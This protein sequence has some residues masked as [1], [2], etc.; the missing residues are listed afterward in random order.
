M[1]S[2]ADERSTAGAGYLAPE[3]CRAIVDRT[4]HPF[5]ALAPDGTVTFASGSIQELS[6]WVPSDVVGRNMVEF[7]AP[8][9]IE[10]AANS[11]LE[12]QTAD[13]GAV[14]I[15]I[16][17][18]ILAPT[19]ES[20]WAEVGAV[21]VNDFHGFDGV[22]L[23]LRPWTHNHYFDRFL[24]ALLSSR[25][26]AEVSEPLCR[27][28]SLSLDAQGALIH[29]GFDGHEFL[30]TEG[31]GVPLVVAPTDAGPW[32]QAALTGRPVH[33]SVAD[34][35]PRARLAAEEP[36]FSAIWC[37]P[38]QGMERLP[39]A[40]LSVWRTEP[41]PPLLGARAGLETQTRYAQLAIQ[42][43]AEHQRLIHIAGHDSLT[44]V[45]N[46]ENFRDRL[47]QALAIG[48][49]NL[50]VAFCDLDEFK[51]VN[52]T[53]GHRTGDLVLVQV[54]DRLRRS[55]RA[56]DE[57]ARVGGDEFTVLMR[58]VPD[59]TA[60]QHLAERLLHATAEPF[61][62]DGHPVHIGISVGV[63]L[64]RWPTSADSLLAMADAALYEAKRNG[65]NQAHVSQ[66]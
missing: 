33:A 19:G 11:F 58:N 31:F 60:A 30:G 5:L 10:K 9:D 8:G 20:L 40:V 66:G 61:D 53:Y 54:A 42:R 7:L 55:L 25:P 48:E 22:I 38:I 43:W 1:S 18:E 28:I 62:A 32:R 50:A 3:L 17:F 15:P 24:D 27:S 46:R 52:D 45:A 34:L 63:A 47:A 35:P 16:I 49:E 14:S 51:P 12:L 44:G 59:A 23:R 41:G 65:G 36:G 4:A 21:R 2:D 29:H 64:V 56:G 39:P 26:F 37:M 6:G 57:L 13:I